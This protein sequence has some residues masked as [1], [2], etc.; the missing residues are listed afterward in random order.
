MAKDISIDK[1]AINTIILLMPKRDKSGYGWVLK[2]FIR[3][4]QTDHT[5]HFYKLSALILTP[6]QLGL[7]HEDLSNIIY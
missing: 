1:K 6:D 5:V 3:D 2:H 7:T 4:L